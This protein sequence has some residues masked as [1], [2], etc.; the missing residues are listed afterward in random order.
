M[1][2]DDPYTCR[3]EDGTEWPEHTFGALECR[4]CG[5]EAQESEGWGVY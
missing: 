4:R 1:D 5:A 3:D 2:E